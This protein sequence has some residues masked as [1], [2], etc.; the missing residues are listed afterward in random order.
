MCFKVSVHI[1]Q[2]THSVLQV[3]HCLARQQGVICFR[4]ARMFLCTRV[5]VTLLMPKE[6]TA[7]ACSILTNICIFLT[8]NVTQIGQQSEKCGRKFRYAPK[9]NCAFSEIIYIWQIWISIDSQNTPTI[10]F[11]DLF[12]RVTTSFGPH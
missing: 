1:W 2:W 11:S 7:F 9:Q 4:N 10:C 6:S 5:N 8:T 12:V 3:L